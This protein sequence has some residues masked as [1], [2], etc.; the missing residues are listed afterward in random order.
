MS[1]Q[2]LAGGG[3]LHED[4]PLGPVPPSGGHGG[5]AGAERVQLRHAPLHDARQH[6]DD[7]RHAQAAHH[8]QGAAAARPHQRQR[9]AA[10]RVPHAQRDGAQ[11]AHQVS[12]EGGHFLL[13]GKMGKWK[14]KI[15][16]PKKSSQIYRNQLTIIFVVDTVADEHGHQHV[17][18]LFANFLIFKTFQQP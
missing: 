9:A 8:G 7:V 11:H 15:E 17:G 14:I 3:G 6:A 18:K 5:P 12:A 4:D 10:G 1:N 2:R 13:F 16:S